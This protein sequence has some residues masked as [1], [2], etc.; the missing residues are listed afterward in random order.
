MRK[1]YRK[2]EKEICSEA[3]IF[4]RVS[5]EKQEKGASIDAQKELI[6][7]YCAKHKLNVIKELTIT[8]STTR[9]DRKQYKEMLE[10]IR[11]K[12]VKSLLW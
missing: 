9:G 10:F 4:A 3:I 6:Y 8:E 7:D 2:I 11:K 5:S 12:I 1:K